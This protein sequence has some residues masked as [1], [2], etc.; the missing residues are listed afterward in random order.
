M[1]NVLRTLG[2]P[3]GESRVDGGALCATLEFSVSRST[4]GWKVK[5]WNKERNSSWIGLRHRVACPDVTGRAVCFTTVNSYSGAQSYLLGGSCCRLRAHL[6]LCLILFVVLLLVLL[7]HSRF[8]SF[9][10]KLSP[11]FRSCLLFSEHALRITQLLNTCLPFISFSPCSFL[12]LFIDRGWLL[13]YWCF[14]L[15]SEWVYLVITGWV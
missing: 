4:G 1:G 10:A 12:N 5:Q 13:Y 15:A 9:F 2:S 8:D 7:F 3:V 11:S 6:W 14:S